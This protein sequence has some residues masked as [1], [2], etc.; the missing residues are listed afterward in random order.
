MARKEKKSLV[1]GGGSALALH[2]VPY[3]ALSGA[4]LSREYQEI[5]SCQQEK[6]LLRKGSLS[7][8]SRKQGG[9]NRE[10]EVIS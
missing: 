7:K 9:V 8:H 6:F 5:W 4:F 2:E 1:Y 3:Q 10:P